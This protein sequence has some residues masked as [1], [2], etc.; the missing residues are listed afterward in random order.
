MINRTSLSSGA[1]VALGERLA[2]RR[3]KAQQAAKD[4][5]RRQQWE[6]TEGGRHE[7]LS[8]RRTAS[9]PGRT[10]SQS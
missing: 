4:Q 1:P 10:G 9:R 6:T 2:E 7:E 3:A 5:Q 8:G